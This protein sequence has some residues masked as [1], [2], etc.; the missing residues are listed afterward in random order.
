MVSRTQ[1]QARWYSVITPLRGGLLIGAAEANGGSERNI[2]PGSLR[3]RQDVANAVTFDTTADV[4][5]Y[6][7]RPGRRLGVGV[8]APLV[9]TR[10]SQCSSSIRDG[11]IA[12]ITTANV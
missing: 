4:S 2:Q 7:C 9:A 6:S 11:A 12:L 1:T 8:S 3:C 10:R 5:N